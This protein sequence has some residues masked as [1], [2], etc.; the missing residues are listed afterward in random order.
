MA[1][2]RTKEIGIRK[3]LGASVARVALILAKE[4]ILSVIFAMLIVANPVKTLRA[5]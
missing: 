5:E 3:I 2:Q 4:F 1:A